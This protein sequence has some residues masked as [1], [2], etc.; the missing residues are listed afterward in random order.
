[1]GTT[2]IYVI[3]RKIKAD[4]GKPILNAEPSKIENRSKINIK[5]KIAPIISKMTI[6]TIFVQSSL[7]ENQ[8]LH[9]VLE[10][11][12]SVIWTLVQYPEILNKV[13]RH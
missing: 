4:M 9:Q 11:N 7:Q 12:F 6:P 10:T 1:M 8:N 13:F 3:Q 5:K 2:I